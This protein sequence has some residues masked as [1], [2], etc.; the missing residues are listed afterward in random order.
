MKFSYYSDLFLS[1][2]EPYLKPATK[3]KYDYIVEKISFLNNRDINDIKSS[4]IR[5]YLS[6]LSKTLTYKTIKD[7]KSVLSQIFDLAKFDE[8]IVKNPIDYIKLLRPIKPKINP[9]N[10]DEVKSILNLSKKYN[11]KFYLYLNIAFYTGARTGEILALKFNNIDFNKKVIKIRSTISK[12]GEHLPKTN[13]SIRNIPIFNN[14]YEILRYYKIYENSSDY[15][16]L[17]QYN[18]PY[19]QSFSYTNYYWKPILKKLNLQYRSLYTTRHTF[20]TNVLKNNILTPYE[21]SYILGHST[22]EMVFNRYVKFLSNQADNF[23]RNLCI[24]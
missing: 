19:K 21:L 1:I 14:L 11:N 5:L 6:N 10:A 13:N 12:F 18:K 16:F 8:V 22:T 20:A 17:N 3:Y 7:Y 23:K 4:E 2:K 24:Y 9:F 15:I